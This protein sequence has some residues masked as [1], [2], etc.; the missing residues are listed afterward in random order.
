MRFAAFLVRYRWPVLGAVALVTA[1]AVALLP[2]IRFDFTPGAAFRGD[3]ELVTY[4]ESFKK[5]FGDSDAVLLVVL[6]STGEAD[7]LA[8]PA[9]TWQARAAERIAE[10]PGVERVD[11]IATLEVPR[12]GPLGA[13]A[14]EPLIDSTP[15]DADAEARVRE[16]LDRLTLVRGTLISEDRTVSAVVARLSPEA[17][18]AAGTRRAVDAVRGV[19]REV[20]PPPGYAAHLSGLPAMRAGI[21][22]NLRSD[23]LTLFPAAGG[24]FLVVLA[25]EFRRISGTL[26][27]L[28]AVGVGLIWTVAL[29]VLRGE[30]FNIISNILPILLFVIG[31]ANCVHVVTRYAEEAGR[32]GG[33]VAAAR[34]TLAHMSVACFLTFFTTAIGFS[35]LLGARSE[36]LEALGWHAVAGMGFLYITTITVLGGLMPSFAAPRLSRE[37]PRPHLVGRCLGVAGRAVA[38]RPKTVLMC[39]AAVIAFFLW[40][41]HTVTASSRMFETYEP[42]HPSMRAVRLVDEKLGGVLPLEVSLTAEREGTFLEPATY[43]RVAEAQRFATGLDA[44]LSARSYVDLHEQARAEI[45]RRMGPFGVPPGLATDD[46]AR[47]EIQDAALRA[48]GSGGRYGAFLTP[49]ARR[50]RIMLKVRDIG[51]RETGEVLDTL[52]AKLDELFPPGSGVEARLTGA[53][54]VHARAMDRFLRDLLMSLLGA[55]LVIFVVIGLLFR[56]LR[57]GLIA[58]LPNLT[59]LV[60]T[61]GYIGLRGYELNA[62]NVIVFAISLGI[63]VDDTIH[64]LARFRE[65][66]R[67]DGDV[68]EAIRRSFHGTGR[69]IVLT[70]VLIVAGLSVLLLSDFMPSRRFAEL[71]NVTMAGALI[72]DLFLLPACLVLFSKRPRPTVAAS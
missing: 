62:G 15:V 58:V 17:M 46:V 4:A 11:A 34:R 13:A 30:S 25:M 23:L 67:V 21:V 9:L 49:D 1:G 44:V 60:I 28:L 18:D 3:D 50:A 39:S 14:T 45:M 41:A 22:A 7:A 64:F 35:A 12:A 68:P 66:V 56:S 71:T 32:G 31:M 16:A 10:A 69:A 55:A 47:L 5:T 57:T 48:A 65:E 53:A 2:R 33:R 8:A 27:P 72:G 24:L 40:S 61:W 29:I 54:Q 36:Q 26:L 19:L 20:P 52:N 51:S 63:A 42:G 59:P 37:G 6:E 70:S 38:R 43:A